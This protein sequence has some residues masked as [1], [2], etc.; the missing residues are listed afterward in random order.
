MEKRNIQNDFLDR[1]KDEGR[2]VT[3][4]TVNGFQ[5]KGLIIS[6]DQ[7]NILLDVDGRQQLVYKS[8]VSTVIRKE[9]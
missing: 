5:M 7:Y 4:I 9:G 3:I 8:A 2:R 6:H 1:L